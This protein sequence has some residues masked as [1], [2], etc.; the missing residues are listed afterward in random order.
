[1][2]MLSG[3]LFG[4]YDSRGGTTFVVANKK[5]EAIAKYN[6]MWNGEEDTPGYEF[7]DYGTK[8]YMGRAKLYLPSDFVFKEGPTFPDLED[9]DDHGF[10]V[11][12]Y[13]TRKTMPSTEDEDFHPD[14]MFKGPK[15]IW[16]LEFV[17]RG[18]MPQHITT[19]WIHPNWY[20]DAF[21][22]I[23]IR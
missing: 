5:A 20:D 12:E 14:A 21:S 11:L 22:F 6:T 2:T 16:I 4:N 23:V 9:G 3:W 15:P 1:M 18:Q 8:Q 10:V 19:G 17:P 13:G 7:F